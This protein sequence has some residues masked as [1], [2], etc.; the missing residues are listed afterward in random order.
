MMEQ[1]SQSSLQSPEQEQQ[2]TYMKDVNELKDKIVN[3]PLAE[4]VLTIEQTI[5]AV[6]EVSN[7]ILEGLETTDDRLFYTDRISLFFGKYL[8]KLKSLLE[9]KDL[10]LAFWAASLLMHH[11]INDT[12]AERILLEAIELS[13]NNDHANT[14]TIILYRNRNPKAIDAI[15]KRL[16]NKALEKKIRDYYIEKRDDLTAALGG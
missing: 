7:I 8:E 13:D 5:R 10:D 11:K 14:A 1:S 6:D 12:L 16:D 2:N 3:K 4:S 15:T 9:G